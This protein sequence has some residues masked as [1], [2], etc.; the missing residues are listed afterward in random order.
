VARL[1][2]AKGFLAE[3]T[4]LRGDEACRSFERTWRGCWTDLARR[5]PDLTG[6]DLVLAEAHIAAAERAWFAK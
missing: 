5:A 2:I 1:A 4:K 6:I 3:Y